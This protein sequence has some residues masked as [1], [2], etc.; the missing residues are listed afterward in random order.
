MKTVS[1]ILTAWLAMIA[2]DAVLGWPL[3]R[4]IVEK[5]VR[6]YCLVAAPKWDTEQ[7]TARTF[8][9]RGLWAGIAAAAAAAAWFVTSDALRGRR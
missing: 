9:S 6:A 5:A 3:F 7:C 2:V 8:Y 4:E 1:W